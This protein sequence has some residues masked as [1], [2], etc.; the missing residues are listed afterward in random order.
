MGILR[1]KIIG[2]PAI[3]AKERLP[4]IIPVNRHGQRVSHVEAIQGPA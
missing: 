4:V 3:I 2:D 1:S